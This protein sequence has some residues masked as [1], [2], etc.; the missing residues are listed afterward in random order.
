MTERDAFIKSA[1]SNNCDCI[2][3]EIIGAA[4]D[5]DTDEDYYTQLTDALNIWRDS[6][7]YIL[8]Q[9]LA[10]IRKMKKPVIDEWYDECCPAKKDLPMDAL[11]HMAKANDLMLSDSL[12]GFAQALITEI[13]MDV[14]IRVKK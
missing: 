7:G 11:E 3:E 6:R 8:S 14:K 12:I 4:W 9:S 1:G 13:N 5:G 10:D 2:D